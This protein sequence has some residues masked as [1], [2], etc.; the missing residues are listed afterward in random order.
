M[1]EFKKKKDNR[2][3]KSVYRNSQTD[4]QIYP[5]QRLQNKIEDGN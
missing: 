3:N 1:L 5:R 2:V 4:T